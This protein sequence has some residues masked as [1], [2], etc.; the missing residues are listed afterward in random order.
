MRERIT[1]P[2]SKQIEY[3]NAVLSL[4]FTILEHKEILLA[5]I[6]WAFMTFFGASFKKRD[7]RNILRSRTFYT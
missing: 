5:W 1:M 3:V 2:D 4:I 7:L 6:F